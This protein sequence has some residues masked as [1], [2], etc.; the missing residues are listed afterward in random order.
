MT[1]ASQKG[2]PYTADLKAHRQL[3]VLV[4]L[5]TAWARIGKVLRPEHVRQD[6]HVR[7]D[8]GRTG[9]ACVAATSDRLAAR[10][11]TSVEVM[12]RGLDDLAVD[13]RWDSPRGGS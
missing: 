13:L 8:H 6:A 5:G 4:L 3:L 9:E 11:S 1:V 10:A 7:F 2:Q 12:S